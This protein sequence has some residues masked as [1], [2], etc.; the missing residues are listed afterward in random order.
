MPHAGM[1]QTFEF[2]NGL[3]W[4]GGSGTNGEGAEVLPP[5]SGF[6]LKSVLTLNIMGIVVGVVVIR[7]I[8]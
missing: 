5:T 4:F 6:E 3:V 1:L 8:S 2:C 7:T